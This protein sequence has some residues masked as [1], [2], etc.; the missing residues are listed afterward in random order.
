MKSDE[1][2]SMNASSPAPVV[3]V[4]RILIVDPAAEARRSCRDLFEEAGYH[5][6]AVGSGREACRAAAQTPFDVVVTEARLPDVRG[7]ALVRWFRRRFPA[8]PVILSS[9]G[10]DWKM[11][12]RAL[13]A[14]ARDVVSKLSPSEELLRVVRRCAPPAAE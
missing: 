10:A 2:A 11:Y 4:R 14:G 1:K 12:F 5:A 6:T 7:L 3:R 8:L 13:R 9:G